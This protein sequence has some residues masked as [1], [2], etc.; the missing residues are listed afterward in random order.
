[1]LGAHP[2]YQGLGLGRAALLAGMRLLLDRG[3]R[4]IELTVDAGNDAAKQLYESVG[5]QRVNSRLWFEAGL[6]A[7]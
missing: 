7:G 3:A 6:N 4:T 2:R 1:M 5:Y